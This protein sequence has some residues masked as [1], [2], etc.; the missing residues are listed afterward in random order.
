MRGVLSDPTRIQDGGHETRNAV[1]EKTPQGGV[2]MALGLAE[3]KVPTDL[4]SS[5]VVQTAPRLAS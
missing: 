5:I 2:E 4:R 3:A 1:G